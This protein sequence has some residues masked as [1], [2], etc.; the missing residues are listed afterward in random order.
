VPARGMNDKLSIL[1]AS[2]IWGAMDFPRYVYDRLNYFN[3]SNKVL[4]LCL[5]IAR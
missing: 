2:D 1:N 4:R 3:A 5:N